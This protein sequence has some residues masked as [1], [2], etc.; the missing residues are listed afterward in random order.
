M[1]AA[2]KENVLCAT[3][4]L[5]DYERHEPLDPLPGLKRAGTKTSKLC[6]VHPIFSTSAFY[7]K[8]KQSLCHANCKLEVL[9]S[10]SP[11]S[12]CS[13]FSPVSQD[14]KKEVSLLSCPWQFISL[15]FHCPFWDT[16]LRSLWEIL[17]DKEHQS[18]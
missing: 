3:P 10:S 7:F 9:K 18:N 6:I 16:D 5:Q 15:P 11:I 8:N 17:E 4:G 1:S 2:K 12:V 14:R 13:H